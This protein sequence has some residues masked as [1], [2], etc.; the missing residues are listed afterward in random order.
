MIDIRPLILPTLLLVCLNSSSGVAGQ[1]SAPN[2]LSRAE[3]W[4]LMFKKQVER[5]WKK[6]VTKNSTEAKIEAVF[7][8]HLKRDGT[9]ESPPRPEKPLRETA[10]LQVYQ[11]SALRALIACQPY[12]LPAAD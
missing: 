1:L 12:D 11:E 3:A 4:G 10:Y 8:I 9:L 6:P 2:P 7:F 5:C